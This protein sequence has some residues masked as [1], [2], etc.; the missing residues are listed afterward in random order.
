[1]AAAPSTPEPDVRSEAIDQPLATATRVGPP[2]SEHIAE[3]QPEHGSVGHGGCQGIRGAG[4][5]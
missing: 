2:E 4:R 3:V 1:M 5:R